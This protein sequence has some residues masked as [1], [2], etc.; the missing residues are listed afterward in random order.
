[1]VPPI[2]YFLCLVLFKVV[3]LYFIYIGSYLEKYLAMYYY[4]RSYMYSHIHVWTCLW[5]L[6]FLHIAMIGELNIVPSL[7]IG[8]FIQCYAY[9]HTYI[10]KFYDPFVAT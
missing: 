5:L 10:V 9:L 6:Q 1:M 2:R 7:T 3:V 8:S 4:I